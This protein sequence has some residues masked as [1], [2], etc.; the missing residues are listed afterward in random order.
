MRKKNGIEEAEECDNLFQIQGGGEACTICGKN[1]HAW[2]KIFW[3]NCRI[4]ETPGHV[5]E[6]CRNSNRNSYQ[7]RIEC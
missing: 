5:A 3:L 2:K 6:M 1:N 4:C 7:R